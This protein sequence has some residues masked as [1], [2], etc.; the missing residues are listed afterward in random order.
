L[1]LDLSVARDFF[2]KK[3]VPRELH[4]FKRTLLFPNRLH[5]PIA[6]VISIG[7]LADSLLN[8]AS[9]FF[10]QLQVKLTGTPRAP[11][12]HLLGSVCWSEADLSD[13]N[14]CGA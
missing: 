1:G 5:E 10:C 2:K 13:P 14:V 4:C 6:G 9:T 12:W 8:L 3:G 7:W 11:H